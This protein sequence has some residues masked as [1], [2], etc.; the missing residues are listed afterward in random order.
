MLKSKKKGYFTCDLLLSRVSHERRT[1]L[2][3]R[4]ETG[5]GED[6]VSIYLESL[7]SFVSRT[8]LT[9]SRGRACGQFSARLV[10]SQCQS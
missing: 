6:N 8:L 4:D 9:L 10:P 1:K 3:I 2:S 5:P 7:L